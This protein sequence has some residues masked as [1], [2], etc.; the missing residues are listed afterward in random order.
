M[1]KLIIV[2]TYIYND[3]TE[4]I[5]KKSL[6]DLKKTGFDILV[7]SNSHIK[8]ETLTNSNYYLFLSD[9]IQ[10]GDD[11]TD[12]PV[13]DFW[14]GTDS[15]EVHHFLPSY[16]KY[17]LSVLRNIFT[18]LDL[19]KSLKYDSFFFVNGD[20]YYGDISI[21]FIKKIPD[22]CT[23]NGKKS[24]YY[25]NNDYDVSVAIFYSDIDYF[26]KTISNIKCED[27]YKHYLLNETKN[28][29]FLDVE[30][31]LYHNLKKLQDN[32]LLIKNGNYL[33]DDFPDTQFNLVTGIYNTS[34][35]Y[36]GCLTG[37][38][39]SIK[40]EKE[41]GFNI[42]S[43]NLKNENVKRSIEVYQN[44]V[45]YVTIEHT[46]SSHVWVIN[47]FDYVKKIKV[48][49]NNILILEED[50]NTKSYIKHK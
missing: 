34:K 43:R 31:F 21:E 42:F 4:K 6:V 3:E 44:D 38:F 19:A 36:N 46:L 20:N 11:Y 28:L 49:E 50:N 17:G 15:F 1:K 32:Y 2:S 8:S 39:K 40:N 47:F 7:V 45:D 9:A 35:V 27:D 41:F 23:S 16:Q 10:F 12:V 24:M 30:R 25:I 5:L 13:L 22:F 14:F 48:Y 29:S 26:L 37:L 18:S 33:L